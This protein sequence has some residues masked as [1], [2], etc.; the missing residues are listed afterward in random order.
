M[1]EIKSTVKTDSWGSFAISCHS[2]I[3]ISIRKITT[4]LHQVSS[5]YLFIIRK[6]WIVIIY[7]S[8]QYMDKACC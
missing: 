4:K 7:I 2:Y 6:K 8:G 1:S 5:F 3:F